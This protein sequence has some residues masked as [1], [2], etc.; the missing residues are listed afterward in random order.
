[1]EEVPILMGQLILYE[2]GKALKKRKRPVNM[3]IFKGVTPLEIFL[4]GLNKNKG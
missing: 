4:T 2:I 3:L 1:M